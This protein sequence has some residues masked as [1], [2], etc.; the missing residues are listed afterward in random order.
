MKLMPTPLV[1]LVEIVTEPH[2]DSRGS[3]TRITCLDEL[4]ALALPGE[5]RL[6]FVQVNL[7]R[8]HQRGTLRGLHFQRAPG[9]E[10]KLIRCLRGAVWD[11]AVDLRPSSATF[12]RWYGTELSEHN[13][14]QLFIPA[15]MAHGFQTLADD[16]ELLYQHTAAYRPELDAG[17]HHADPQLGITWPLPPREVS[18]RDLALPT[19]I[20]VFGDVSRA[21][22]TGGSGS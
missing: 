21:S 3:F 19:L 10:A 7:S 22:I 20:D 9:R 6:H 14:H 16:T 4:S 1:G 13:Q 2:R 17:V 12:G 18:P 5:A 15:G 11:V 8:S